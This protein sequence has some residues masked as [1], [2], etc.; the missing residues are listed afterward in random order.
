LGA[1]TI[2]TAYTLMFIMSFF[3]LHYMLP[4]WFGDDQRGSTWHFMQI[5]LVIDMCF[6]FTGLAYRDKQ[7]EMDKIIFQEQLIQQL[8][9]N[10]ALQG[11]FTSELQQQ[12]KKKPLN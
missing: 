12:V 10:K 5:A 1:L 3:E 8:E 4:A 6:Y 7:V 2:F 11:K 9:A